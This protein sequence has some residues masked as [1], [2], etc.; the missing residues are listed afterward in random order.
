MKA[1]SS[2]GSSCNGCNQTAEF[3]HCTIDAEGNL[4]EAISDTGQILNFNQENTMTDRI[5]E[6][7][8]DEED[9][10]Q[11]ADFIM[12]AT[13]EYSKEFGLTPFQAYAS[14]HSVLDVMEQAFA[15]QGISVR[16]EE[17]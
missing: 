3:C 12:H 7:R 10:K 6:H 14:L 8:E 2:Y 5:A 1:F 4:I 13:V 9:V 16:Q 15:E 11:F 17:V